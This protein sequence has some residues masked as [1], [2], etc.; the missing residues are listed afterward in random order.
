MW[1]PSQ[2][3]QTVR[4][5]A[6]GELRF[7]TWVPMLSALGGLNSHTDPLPRLV[8]RASAVLGAGCAKGFKA[9]VSKVKVK[10]VA[11]VAPLFFTMETKGL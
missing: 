2:A 6:S 11:E 8:E 1:S 9:E 10:E 4:P 5:R 3:R 7:Q